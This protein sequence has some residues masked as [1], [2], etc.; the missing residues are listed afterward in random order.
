MPCLF[1]PVSP[2][3]LEP[4]FHFIYRNQ[5]SSQILDLH[6]LEGTF[7]YTQ[8]KGKFF[9]KEERSRKRPAPGGNKTHDLYFAVPQPFAGLGF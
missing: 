7:S 8:F 1:E 2:Q 9:E 3:A 4:G 6:L 5:L